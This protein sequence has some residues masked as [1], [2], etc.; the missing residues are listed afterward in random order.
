M[1]R[2]PVQFLQQGFQLVMSYLIDKIRKHDI[3]DIIKKYIS[4]VQF[5]NML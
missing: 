2:E 1:D 4:D 5:V 3:N